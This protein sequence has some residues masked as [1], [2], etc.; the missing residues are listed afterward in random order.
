MN[1]VRCGFDMRL[2][3]V[4]GAVGALF[5]VSFVSACGTSTCTAMEPGE[6]ARG[7]R[8]F[9]I[10][11]YDGAAARCDGS[12]LAAGA[13]APLLSRSAAAG[14]PLTIDVPPGR[15]TLVLI[16][17][18]DD[19]GTQPIGS[20]CTES[21]LG[22]ASANCFGL[23]VEPLPDLG[24]GCGDGG[25][26]CA[27]RASPDS[28]PSGS[29]CAANGECV[30]GCKAPS[31][32]A[33]PTP[34]CDLVQHRCVECVDA[35]DC[36]PGKR[37]SPSGRC[38]DGCDVNAGAVC[39]GT[40][41]CCTNVCIDTATD[42]ASCGACGRACSSTGVAAPQ[43]AGGLCT[44]Q[45]LAGRG[46]CNRPIA[47]APDDGC[48][49][50]LFTTANCGA[51]N[52][53][54][55]LDHATPKCPTGT[56]LIESCDS[57]HFDCDGA[58]ATG[59]ECA[60]VDKNDGQKGCCPGGK[61]Q[62]AHAN[63]FGQTFYSCTPAGTFDQALATDAANSYSMSNAMAPFQQT[64]PNGTTKV[65]CKRSTNT[66]GAN[67]QCVCWAYEDSANP[68]VVGKALRVTGTNTCM[69]PT[70]TGTAWQ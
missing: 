65:V 21:D 28:C 70:S 55:A 36:A 47:P 51:C 7:A 17:F 16:A 5:S 44:P 32:C 31:D 50:D 33:A 41:A 35:G 52:R 15:R 26:E 6:L 27:C 11:V 23:K 10:D 22:G 18:A 66:N 2:L 37:C 30:S 19:A 69:C 3:S 54:C 42:V 62:A 60:G 29:W 59:C 43:C 40:L 14:Q 24:A 49:T 53:P 4:V 57:G 1:T 63:G 61:C 45:C 8:L 68:A 58:A 38:V 56:C 64:C 20:A 34:R 25:G 67:A 48:E 9:R 39:P 13:P 46:D 12:G